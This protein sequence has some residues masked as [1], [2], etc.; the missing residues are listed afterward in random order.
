MNE[1]ITSYIKTQLAAGVTRSDIREALVA[2][3]WQV[4]DIAVAFQ[5]VENPDALPVPQATPAAPTTTV[6]S[7]TSTTN[8]AKWLAAGVVAA[9]VLLV[10]GGTAYAYFAFFATQAPLQI[11]QKAYTNS[12]AAKTYAF[13]G[14]AEGTISISG[15][16]SD[17]SQI[18]AAAST[19]SEQFKGVGSG[20]VDVTD[21]RHPR[22]DITST[23]SM[24]F[25]I[26]TSSSGSADVAGRLISLDR[27]AYFDLTHF[28]FGLSGSDSQPQAGLQF[29][30]ALVNGFANALQNKWI[31]ADA[32]TTTASFS[33]IATSS[34]QVA[35]D[36]DA[37]KK[38]GAGLSYIQSVQNKGNES[39]AGV[40]M[41]HLGVTIQAGNDFVS[42]VKSFLTDANSD[43]ATASSTGEIMQELGPVL[44]QKVTAD[45]WVGKSDYRI[46]QIKLSPL[47]AVF[48]AQGAYATTTLSSETLSLS[49]YDG[50]VSITA[51][52]GAQSLEDVFGGL[53]GLSTSTLQPVGK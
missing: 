7:M 26:G 41:Y 22:L 51:P 4:E 45:V 17:L 46:Y 49:N 15:V 13:S 3:G 37:L 20:V 18:G 2:S 5:A 52:Q 43:V 32:T 27:K 11:L 31:L 29:A 9:G 24:Q 12:L 39:L 42:L 10:G 19:V 25:T 36:I 8:K 16:A 35:A 1:Q 21:F 14:N 6:V 44:M 23:S 50:P 48:G 38:Y 33:Q 47:S 28:N 53:F 34:P 30:V 40:D